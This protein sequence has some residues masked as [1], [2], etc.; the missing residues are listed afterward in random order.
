MKKPLLFIITLWGFLLRLYGLDSLPIWIDEAISI[1]AA[2]AVLL[3]GIPLL[4]AGNLYL[5]GL[6][7]SYLLASIAAIANLF[8]DGFS[9]YLMRLPS[10]LVGTA[11][12]PIV[13]YI[14]SKE[15]NY[16][17]GLLSAAFIAFNYY[18]IA[19]S[20]Q[21]R[22]YIFLELFLILAIWYLYQFHQKR[23]KNHGFLALLF[24][25]LAIFTHPGG[26]LI[27]PVAL[28]LVGVRYHSLKTKHKIVIG[29]ALM[30]AAYFALNQLLN[31]H[32]SNFL[33]MHLTW[34]KSAYLPIALIGLL[35]LLI[36][37]RERFLVGV[38]LLQLIYVSFFSSLYA[39]RYTIHVIPLLAILAF[40]FLD[41]SL[42][43]KWMYYVLAI[44][45]IA[46]SSPMI[47]PAQEVYLEPDTPQPPWN[48]VYEYVAQNQYQLTLSD[49]TITRRTIVDAH[50]VIADYY[51]VT[52]DGWLN[53]S[54]TGRRVNKTHDGY[55]GIPLMKPQGIVVMDVRAWQTIDTRA[56]RNQSYKEFGQ[57][58]WRIARVY[59][60]EPQPFMFDFREKML[61]HVVNTKI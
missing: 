22:M 28:V 15:W 18:Q 59:S 60:I 21:A 42:D 58:H 17:V 31:L 3:H 14:V 36:G 16:R 55:L 1:L 52:V 38:I 35:A 27:V 24:S 9:L 56:F 41:E 25:L 30:I 48:E 46:F 19:W 49:A 47:L 40:V 7:Q 11:L 8:T 53:S 4:P 29:C 51:G 13:Y 37:W 45:L 54:L 43:W 39:H 50:P 23:H 57:E 44:L 26:L 33:F 61:W 10:V 6:P 2:K 34:I 20:R 32:F 12:I 5:S